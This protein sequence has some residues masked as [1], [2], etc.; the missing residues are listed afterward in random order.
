MARRPKL[1]LVGSPD[2][3]DIFDDLTALRQEQRSLGPQRRQRLAETFARIP[4]ARAIE[5]TRHRVS[6]GAW[7]ILV[8]LDR[9]ILKGHGR[10]P[11]RLTNR[12]L[13]AA[14][15]S[16]HM[17]MRALRQ[18]EAAGVIRIV[19][20]RPKQAPLVAHLWYPMQD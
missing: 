16:R 6:G 15:I 3:T 2:P 11:V 10:N 1:R 4:H 9:L 13:R 18:L 19:E 5:L 17:K 14:G 20:S 8:E 12:N 7:F